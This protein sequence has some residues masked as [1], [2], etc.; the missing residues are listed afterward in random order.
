[1]SRGRQKCGLA[2]AFATAAISPCKLRN[3][4]I[5]FSWEGGSREPGP[6]LWLCGCQGQARGIPL[7]EVEHA[8]R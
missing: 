4:D 8:G 5:W 6:R 2:C 7:A 1:M 3:N